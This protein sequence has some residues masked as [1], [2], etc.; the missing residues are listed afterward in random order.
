MKKKS[1]N[2]LKC[3]HLKRPFQT[4]RIEIRP[5]ETWGLIFDPYWL[6]QSITFY[7]ELGCISWKYLNSENIMIVSILQ[8]V[9]E[10]YETI[11]YGDTAFTYL[12]SIAQLSVL[13]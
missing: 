7:A 10:L 1:Y 3:V 5:H 12:T 11:V 4:L 9:P 6:I 8:T 2:F 13:M